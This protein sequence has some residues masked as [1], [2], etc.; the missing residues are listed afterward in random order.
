MASSLQGFEEVSL[1]EPMAD[2]TMT[3]T[4]S[5]VRFNKA[6]AEV[7]GWPAYAKILINDRK[8]QIAVQACEKDEPNAVKFSKPEGKQ[9]ASVNVKEP[10]VL[11]A[12]HKY[13]TPG[14]APEGETA[15]QSVG[16]IVLD[17]PKAVV[18]DAADAVAG[19]MKHRG[20]KKA[21]A[22]AEPETEA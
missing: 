9:I 18:F 8:K 1:T 16:G 15:Y 12:V 7:L 14:E 3:V 17:N 11:V 5:V 4:N 10:L 20:R 13:L 19:S 2:V 22:K 21:E 6:T